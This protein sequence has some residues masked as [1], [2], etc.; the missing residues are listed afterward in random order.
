MSAPPDVVPVLRPGLPDE[1]LIALLQSVEGG[2]LGHVDD[3]RAL[4]AEVRR[5]RWA[6]AADAPRCRCGKW[7]TYIGSYD[8]DGKT[9]RCYGCLRSIAR[10]RC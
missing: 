6:A 7:R 8:A 4:V 5:L 3:L 2:G 10:C 1:D 9:V